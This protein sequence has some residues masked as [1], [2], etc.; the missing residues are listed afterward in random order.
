MFHSSFPKFVAKFVL[1][2]SGL[3][4]LSPTL[5]AALFSDSFDSSSLNGWTTYNPLNSFGGSFTVSHPL[6]GKV[7]LRSAISPNPA[8]LGPG[9]GAIYRND[10]PLPG[11][12]SVSVEFSDYEISN[13]FFG[14]TSRMRQ[15]GLGT[16]DAY[17]V[18]YSPQWFSNFPRARFAID[19]LD[20][21]Q[22]TSLAEFRFDE[23]PYDGNYRLELRVQ[24]NQLTGV[25]T[26]LLDPLNPVSTLTATDSNYTGGVAGLFVAGSLV[27]NTTTLVNF[28]NFSIQS[29]PEPGTWAL[30]L[31]A[32]GCVM[33]RCKNV[34]RQRMPAAR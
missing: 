5:Q 15:V 7:Q 31:A 18:S 26:N 27:N 4:G 10:L 33:I 21:E 17:V 12:H 32:G 34:S 30:L 8:S 20:N 13:Q 29:I 2:L 28:D 9:R 23:L 14:V 24:G 16:L 6:P 25:L 19:R 22:R 11:D 3:L 1:S